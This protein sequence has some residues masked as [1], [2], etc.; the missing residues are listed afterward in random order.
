MKYSSKG[1][2]F[3]GGQAKSNS[4]CTTQNKRLI[5]SVSLSL[6]IYIYK[7]PSYKLE[8]PE[9]TQSPYS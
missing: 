6:Y 7:L 3:R 8:N 9:E 5:Q 4:V 2:L 1:C